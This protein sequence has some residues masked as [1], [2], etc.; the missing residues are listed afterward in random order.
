MTRKLAGI[1]A[2]AAEIPR[3]ARI[4]VAPLICAI[5]LAHSATAVSAESVWVKA[6]GA[7]VRSGP[8]KSADIVAVAGIGTKG[9][10][11]DRAGGWMKVRLSE[12]GVVAEGYMHA[13][14]LSVATEVPAVPGKT[15]LTLVEAE[16]ASREAATA[17]ERFAV[18]AETAVR[19]RADARS[20]AI[21]TLRRGNEVP[22]VSVVRFSSGD[23]W[24][25]VQLADGRSGYVPLSAGTRIAPPAAPTAEQQE[26]AQ[27]RAKAAEQ[28]AEERA[29][30]EMEENLEAEREAARA[31]WLRSV[32]EAQAAREAAERAQ[33][34]AERTLR[35]ERERNRK[36]AFD[37]VFGLEGGSGDPGNGSGATVR[38][39]G[40]FAW[41]KP[42]GL[43]FQAAGMMER[44]GDLRRYGASGGAGYERTWREQNWGAYLFVDALQFQFAPCDATS[45]VQVRPL[46]RWQRDRW[47]VSGFAGLPITRDQLAR[48]TVEDRLYA[49]SDGVHRLTTSERIYDKALFFGG[50]QVR[51]E[52]TSG[53][54][55][56]LKGEAA[57]GKAYRLAL[58]GEYNL[59][60]NF[61]A[62]L[63][64][65]RTDY[66]DY[67][68]LGQN[69]YGRGW[70]AAL[71]IVYGRA[72]GGAT[73]GR[74]IVEPSWPLVVQ[75]RETSTSDEVIADTLSVTATATPDRGTSPLAVTLIATAT[76]GLTPYR[77]QWNLGD[78]G[79]AAGRSVRHVYTRRG[80]FTPNVVVTDAL[81]QSASAQA[82]V[83]VSDTPLSLSCSANPAE[84]EA[85]LTVRF[86]G[87]AQGGSGEYEFAWNLG[88]GSTSFERN[89]THVYEREGTYTAVVTVA[90]GSETA[91]CRRTI[92]VGAPA[93]PLTV[94]CSA[95]GHGGPAPYTVRLSAGAYGG[96][97][98]Y[99]FQWDTDDG[100]VT[101]GHTIQHT[102]QTAGVYNPTVTVTDARGRRARCRERIVVT[103]P[104]PDLAVTCSA[105]QT[106]VIAPDTVRFSVTA[107][108]G[109]GNYAYHWT[110]S[111]DGS[112]SNEREPVHEYQCDAG[113][114]KAVCTVTSGGETAEC[115]VTIVVVLPQIS[116]DCDATP[117]S[118]TAPLAVQFSVTVTGSYNPDD[119][120][121]FWQFGDGEWTDEQNPVHTYA[122][123]GTY[124]AE[125]AV[126][127]GCETQVCQVTVTVN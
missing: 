90:C 48:E 96:R 73:R 108:G 42:H 44:S 99:S 125:V 94:Q 115:E 112:T 18:T 66:G 5:V 95:S 97:P 86:T 10:L 40:I 127:T 34:A 6:E 89:V 121:F 53:F 33:A 85:P 22:L 79:T 21:H 43:W 32:D 104:Q 78:S 38:G 71:G 81:G 57:E 17:G 37:Y 72:G 3:I 106:R 45:H 87:T 65:D 61:Y 14:L 47:T 110:F 70:S 8:T 117:T 54:T 126:T 60:S 111:D 93:E 69:D 28:E 29:R 74:L 24:A 76:G 64:A 118:G 101:S 16:P 103:A 113:T 35:E 105:S 122:T 39:G 50:G 116:L 119:I 27:L 68:L 77:Y 49:G 83:E 15:R 51:G 123:P 55:L 92:E 98:P 2:F 80:R 109:T 102:Y 31:A 41:R 62:V 19:V 7:N 67:P 114:Y 88:D 91:S 11:L 75:S 59:G 20:D 12:S 4:W 84:G 124:E 107:T 25:N 58:T 36:I 120:G 56:A 23:A 82:T 100:T 13:S 63:R 46:V 30:R 9:E 52:L 1:H 26:L